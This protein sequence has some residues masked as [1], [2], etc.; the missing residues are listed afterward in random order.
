MKEMIKKIGVRKKLKK[1]FKLKI[2]SQS[3]T[4]MYFKCQMK[5]GRHLDF[6]TFNLFLCNDF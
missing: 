1:N 6:F 4:R 3:F 2:Q 5:I